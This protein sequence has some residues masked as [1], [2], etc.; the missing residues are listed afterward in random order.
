MIPVNGCSVESINRGMFTTA[1]EKINEMVDVVNHIDHCVINDNYNHNENVRTAQ[2]NELSERISKFEN[3]GGLNQ[4]T[5]KE[6]KKYVAETEAARMVVE[7][8]KEMRKLKEEYDQKLVFAKEDH[9]IPY[10]KELIKERARLDAFAEE[11]KKLCDE[12]NLLKEDIEKLV[13]IVHNLR[14]V[15]GGVK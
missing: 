11:N 13:S 8:L 5:A 6:S 1:I 10:Q 4:A 2:I 3:N 7:G 9:N 15:Y 14:K 12:N